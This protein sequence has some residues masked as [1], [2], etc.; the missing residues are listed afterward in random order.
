MQRPAT[1]TV[2]PRLWW[3]KE[4]QTVSV[5]VP[6]M[7]RIEVSHNSMIPSLEDNPT[8]SVQANGN[9]NVAPALAGC[10]P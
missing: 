7:T 10:K 3:G 6:L 5:Y 2:S 9:G 8:S 1:N 4:E